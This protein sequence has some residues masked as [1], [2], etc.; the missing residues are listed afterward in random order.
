MDKQNALYT[1]HTEASQLETKTQTVSSQK[2]ILTSCL[3]DIKNN[4]MTPFKNTV[5]GDPKPSFFLS[6]SY[7]FCV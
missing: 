4:N 6:I 3:L 5:P 2:H 1:K 7:S